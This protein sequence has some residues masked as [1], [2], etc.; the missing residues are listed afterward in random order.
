MFKKIKHKEI[1]KT[2]KNVLLVTMLLMANIVFAQSTETRKVGSFHKVEIGGSFNAVL[3]QG[4][5][6]SVKII[7][8]N[9]DTK[10][11]LTETNDG[12]LKISL[13]NGNYRNTRI[14]VEVTYKNLDA[15]DRSGSGNLSCESDLSST[16]DFNLSSSGSG[17]I[18]INGK[19]IAAGDAKITRSGSGNMSLKGLQA[20]GVHMNF[21]GSGNFEVN[22]GNAKTQV[23]RLAG[24]GNVS[25]Y[26]LKTETCS[27]SVSGSGDIEIYVSNS[28][29][30][31]ITG[32]GNIDYRGGG[33][34][35]NMEIHGSGRIDKKG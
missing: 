26:G 9:V 2:V 23:I 8:E 30:A 18:D 29:E 15:I 7:A 5:E 34:V 24:S 4:D 32:S 33:Q 17:N 22:E 20:K 16:G 1:M 3:R 12:T 10:K 14:K 35:K 11:I 31:E 6:T 25:A 19:I 27:V 28:L 13:E 21:S